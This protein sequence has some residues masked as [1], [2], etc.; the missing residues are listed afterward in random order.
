[1]TSTR[2][3]DE[4]R[5]SQ[6]TV[7]VIMDEGQRGKSPSGRHLWLEAGQG[8]AGP[9]L[10]DHCLGS[11]LGPS[12]RGPSEG[13]ARQ[14][15]SPAPARDLL[16]ELCSTLHPNEPFRTVT[17]SILLQTYATF[18]VLNDP[19][20]ESWETFPNQFPNKGSTGH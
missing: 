11:D 2:Q 10:P 13:T 7:T 14:Q 18:R 16:Y 17:G 4:A 1:M 8:G 3:H 12:C 5:V 9:L 20:P 15:S 19:V 6:D